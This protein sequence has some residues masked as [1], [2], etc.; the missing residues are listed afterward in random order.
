MAI[1]TRFH[2]TTI[3]RPVTTAASSSSKRTNVRLWVT[4]G[5]L[6]ALFLFAGVGKLVTPAAELTANAPFS[7]SFLYFIG[8]AELLGGIGVVLPWALRIKPALTPIAAAGLAIIM[9]GAAVTVAFTMAPALACINLLVAA[10]AISVVTGRR[11]FASR[12][13]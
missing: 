4:Q 7:A 2:T 8:V 6:A 13:R 1:N 5:A 11:D 3:A 12:T 9:V 10:L